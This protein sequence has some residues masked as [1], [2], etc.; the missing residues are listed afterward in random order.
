M[1]MKP[2]IG[3]TTQL[4]AVGSMQL[5]WRCYTSPVALA[6]EPRAGQGTVRGDCK[7]GLV[8]P[9]VSD[10]VGLGI[11]GKEPENLYFS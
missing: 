9:S 6:L 1:G 2:A 10:S 11:R 4:T 8:G 3:L 5:V 7:H